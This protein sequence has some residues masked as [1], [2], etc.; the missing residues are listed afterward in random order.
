[1]RE[2]AT[3][4]S[5]AGTVG[6]VL[7]RPSAAPDGLVHR[8]RPASVLGHLYQRARLATAAPRAPTPADR[9]VADRH[10][11]TGRR[12]R[13]KAQERVAVPRNTSPTSPN[14]TTPPISWAVTKPATDAGAIPAN[15]SVEALPTVTAGLANDVDN[16]NQYA[17]HQSPSTAPPSATGTRT[18][19]APEA[20]TA[21]PA[22]RSA[23][24]T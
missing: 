2:S 12:H 13:P 18:D 3:S 20:R 23:V 21:P 14:P 19:S 9:T 11:V 6:M 7:F 4:T 17:A 16:V 5:P 8:H 1:M 10:T 24:V 15:L 22:P